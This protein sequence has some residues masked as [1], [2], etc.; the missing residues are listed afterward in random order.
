MAAKRWRLTDLAHYSG[1]TYDTV[2]S[3]KTGRRPNTSIETVQRLA[4]ALNTS[5]DYLLNETDDKRGKNKK[6]LPEQ[7]ERLLEIAGRLSEARQEELRHIAEAL[8]ILERE[9]RVVTTN[10]VVDVAII[11]ELAERLRAK[12]D[13]DLL[14]LLERLIP[15][16][17]H[18]AGDSG[19]A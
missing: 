3:L 12:G 2:Y 8:E 11:L 16:G 14:A 19:G 17:S 5:V 9:Q 18:G 1:V 7:V 6:Q 4:A 13:D 15:P 10:A